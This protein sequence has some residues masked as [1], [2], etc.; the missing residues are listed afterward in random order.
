MWKNY[1]R[2]NIVLEKRKH[3]SSP[4]KCSEDNKGRVYIYIQ[5]NMTTTFRDL[6][7]YAAMDSVVIASS[8]H[9]AMDWEYTEGV[10]RYEEHAHW[11]HSLSL[12][13]SSVWVTDQQLDH[14]HLGSEKWLSLPTDSVL[15]FEAASCNTGDASLDLFIYSFIF[16]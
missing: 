13:F 3:P 1:K 10:S 15:L 11:S 14:G 7:A 16:C 9:C 12:A 5:Y 2:L 4:H 8:S 6:R